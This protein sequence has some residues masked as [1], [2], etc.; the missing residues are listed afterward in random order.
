M[1]LRSRSHG[2]HG[3]NEGR[4]FIYSQ[5]LKITSKYYFKA[6]FNVPYE[7]RTRV[8]LLVCLT[9]SIYTSYI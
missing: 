9:L 2:I 8:L 6:Y 3:I 1:Y 4:S 5:L 7:A